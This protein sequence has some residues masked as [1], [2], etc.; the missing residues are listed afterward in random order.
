MKTTSRFIPY[1]TTGLFSN[2]I[3][4]Y[5]SSSPDL[6]S[7]YAHEPS[8][9]GI[10]DA[11]NARK[12]FPANRLCI[13]QV[14]QEAYAQSQPS[15]SQSHNISLLS[16]EKTFTICAAHQPNIFSGYLYFIYKTAHAIALAE[17]LSKQLPD[18]HFVP[19]FYIGSEDNDLIELSRFRLNGKSFQ[20]NTDQT[21]AVGRMK[22]DKKVTEL[23]KLIEAEIGHLPF[24]VDLMKI[25]RKAYASGN[26]MAMGT[27]VLLNELFKDQGLL[28]L[29]PDHSVLKEQMKSVFRDDLLCNTANEVVAKTNSKL[30]EKYKLQVNPRPVNLFYL[31][32]GIRNRIDKRGNIYTVDDSAIRFTEEEILQEL[33]KFPERFS[34]NVILRGLYQETIL[35]NIVF[36]GGGSELAY[37]MQ[38]NDLFAHYHI[39]FPVLILRNSFVIMDASHAH[40]LKELGL[41]DADLFKDKTSLAN[42]L[43]QQWGGK[44]ISLNV[45]VEESKMLFGHLKQRAGDVDK[46][47]VQHVH[48]LQTIH[49]KKLESLEKKMLRSERKKQSVQLQ[50]IWKIKSE[51]FPNDTLQERVD[52]FMPYY[53]KYG[54][55]FINNILGHSLSLEQQFGIMVIES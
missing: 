26:D 6:D 19:V 34:P 37:W 14:F 15:D 3:N 55:D 24:A 10:N 16:D 22:A 41:A 32:D 1:Q 36:I 23:I 30:S 17:S 46:T 20:W 42:T 21:G 38:L 45:E 39:P 28:V 13:Q 54:K 49:L 52:N 31:R 43:V 5:L 8:L 12:Q 11:I 4:D 44:E 47:L 9:D 48:A 27:F 7:F 18:Y 2:F 29:Q 53:A 33:D 40:K 25:L 35:P 51:L 50:R